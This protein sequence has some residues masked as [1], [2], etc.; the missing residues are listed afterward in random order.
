MKESSSR[1][2]RPRKTLR[3]TFLIALLIFSSTFYSP[4]ASALTYDQTTFAKV[5]LYGFLAGT[6]MGA[7][8]YSSNQNLRS[9]FIGS[10]VGLYLGTAV[11]IY[12]ITHRLDPENPLSPLNAQLGLTPSPLSQPMDRPAPSSFK[13]AFLLPVIRF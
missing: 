8:V 7:V 13:I 6:L 5:A 9:V 3:K 2:N 12:H 1:A 11:G 4:K 10:S